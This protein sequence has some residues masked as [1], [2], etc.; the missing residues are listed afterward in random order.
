MI[1]ESLLDTD[2]Y[3][4][5]MMQAV[6]H[7]FPAAQV[8]YRF[9]C[10]TPAAGLVS[11]I[12]RIR[13]EVAALCSLRFTR[14]ELDYL[15]GLRYL[16]KDFVDILRI[17]QLQ[18]EF[19]SIS[20]SGGELEI[21]IRGPWLH[22]I[23]F[24]VPLLAIL[25]ELHAESRRNASSL[26]EGEARLDAKIALLRA[27]PEYRAFRFSEFGTRRRC[28]RDWQRTVV[29]R[30]AEAVSGNLAGTSNVL[31]A[32]QLGL[33]P[34]GTMGHEFLQACQA[35]GP[36]LADSQRFA[37]ETWAQEYR[38]DLGIALSDVIGIDAFLRD[39]DLYFC[40][41][42]DGVRQDS[43]DPF[44]WGEKLLAHYHKLRV[45]PLGKTLV[46]TDALDMEKALRIFEHFR[47]RTRLGFGIGTHLSNDLG[48]APPD[49]IIKMTRCNGQA[50][51]KISDDPAK[52]VCLDAAYLAYLKKVFAAQ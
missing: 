47:A 19:V 14:E 9:H 34:I 17:F 21:V 49:M 30:L 36:R 26:R 32:K 43:G 7:H 27:R 41:L 22:T 4:F 29:R 52:T 13:A 5:T 11:N 46:F 8:E 25:S 18:Q 6:L 38:G 24:E 45:D 39:F 12:E 1:I 2:L 20:A 3:K 31:L 23:L 28:S 48:F 40:K 15:R 33:T 37:L 35:L 51:A 50:V 16:K 42:F 44:V 10:R